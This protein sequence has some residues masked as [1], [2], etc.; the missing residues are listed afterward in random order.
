[1]L[2]KNNRFPPLEIK[3]K[4]E[5]FDNAKNWQSARATIQKN[6]YRKYFKSDL[7][8]ICVVCFYNKII[9]VAHIK[10]VSS[11]SDETLISVINSLDNLTALCPNHHWEFDKGLI[12]LSDFA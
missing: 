11:F 4:K 3:T 12:K 7:P 9:H 2:S 8:K 6:A 1:M 10:D 5:V